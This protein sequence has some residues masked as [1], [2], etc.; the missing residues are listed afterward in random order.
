M[1]SGRER[2]RL[3]SHRRYVRWQKAEQPDRNQQH[4]ERTPHAY[5]T[6]P[7]ISF[8]PPTRHQPLPPVWRIATV[9]LCHGRSLFSGPSAMKRLSQVQIARP[10]AR[11]SQSQRKLRSSPRPSA[12]SG[13]AHMA[14]STQRQSR[15]PSLASANVGRGMVAASGGRSEQPASAATATTHETKLAWLKLTHRKYRNG[16]HVRNG[17]G[18]LRRLSGCDSLIA[19]ENRRSKL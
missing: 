6:H 8:K 10:L 18:A 3:W 4:S 13:M 14:D 5:A 12:I 15:S 17:R 9:T 16:R 19:D 11:S 1:E 2:P 7:P